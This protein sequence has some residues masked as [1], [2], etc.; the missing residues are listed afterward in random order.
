VCDDGT[1]ECQSAWKVHKDYL[2]GLAGSGDCGFRARWFTVRD[3][4]HPQ[5]L[6]Q[7]GLLRKFRRC[8]LRRRVSVDWTFCSAGGLLQQTQIILRLYRRQYQAGGKVRG[9]RDAVD[10]VGMDTLYSRVS[11]RPRLCAC[12]IS[13]RVCCGP[14]LP[15]PDPHEYTLSPVAHH[16]PRASSAPGSPACWPA[17]LCGSIWKRG[18]R[19]VPS[20]RLIG[21][22]ADPAL[23][24]TGRRRL[25]LRPHRLHLHLRDPGDA[26]PS[27][28]GWIGDDWV[29][30]ERRLDDLIEQH[31][32]PLPLQANTFIPSTRWPTTAPPGLL[33]AHFARTR[34]RQGRSRGFCLT[35]C[36]W[37]RG[38]AAI[39]LR[40][41]TTRASGAFTNEITADWCSRFVPIPKLDDVVAGAWA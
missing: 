31:I 16:H 28:S 29:E 18:G 21:T 27:S 41:L 37:T 5:G 4:R 1:A 25:P 17:A 14:P 36:F 3:R 7:R 12:P 40:S 24:T 30:I 33:E 15:R 35:P 26:G 13:P 20:S 11:A 34:P 9:N 6:V 19:C 8:A 10:P 23:I 2:S 38:S 39:S 22:P 32:T